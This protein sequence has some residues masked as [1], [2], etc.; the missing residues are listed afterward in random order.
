MSGL[1]RKKKKCPLG[2]DSVTLMVVMTGYKSKEA[3]QHKVDSVRK[4]VAKIRSK[5]QEPVGQL[6][7]GKGC[8]QFDNDG[9]QEVWS[10]NTGKGMDLTSWSRG[11]LKRNQSL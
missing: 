8:C 3:K 1:V 5:Q 9:L 10:L 2:L 4:L 6:K 7:E 11:G